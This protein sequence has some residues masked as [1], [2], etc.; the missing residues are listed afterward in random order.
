MTISYGPGRFHE[1]GQTP[2]QTLP[3]A[4]QTSLNRAEIDRRRLR[5]L[6]E[7]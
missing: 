1:R 4:M 5:D 7:R 3:R 6:F 2:T